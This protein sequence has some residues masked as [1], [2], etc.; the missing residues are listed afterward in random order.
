ML[1][2]ITHPEVVIDPAV[3]V[4]DWPL[5]SEGVRRMGLALEQPWMSKLGSVFSS[6][7]RKARDAASLVADRFG[8]SPVILADLGE[9]DRSATG[10]LPKAEFEDT[11]NLFFAHPERSVRGWERA[12]DAQRRIRAAVERVIATAPRNGDIA[13][14]SHGGVGAL[15]LCHL[16]GLPISRTEDQPGGGGGCVYSFD[17]GS[18][19]LLSGWRLI[20][21]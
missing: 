11:A 2:F 1:H 5:S 21:E 15:L 19:T 8:I 9:N 16:K 7:E 4:P 18:R 20:D 17:L 10:Y 12:V 6:A 14:I 13:I 3:P